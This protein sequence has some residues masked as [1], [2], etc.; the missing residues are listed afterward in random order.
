MIAGLVKSASV[1]RQPWRRGWRRNGPER[2]WDAPYEQVYEPRGGNRPAEVVA[3]RFVAAMLAQERQLFRLLDAF[4][5]D[6]QVQAVRHLDH[7]LAATGMNCAG[8]TNPR[9]G[10][11]HRSS[12]SAPVINPVRR[13]IGW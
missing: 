12:A 8:D 2:I 1:M 3:L 5:D 13:S 9:V 11:V 6:A 7:G 4:R 10:C